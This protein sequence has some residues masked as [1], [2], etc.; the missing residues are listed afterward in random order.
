MSRQNLQKFSSVITVNFT[1]LVFLMQH[2]N[3]E[4]VDGGDSSHFSHLL[5]LLIG[6]VF[7]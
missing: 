1:L 2:M 5:L 6:E 7:S 4:L 3:R